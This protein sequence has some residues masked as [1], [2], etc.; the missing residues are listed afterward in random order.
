VF[1]VAEYPVFHILYFGLQK[2]FSDALNEF[3]LN[4]FGKKSHYFCGNVEST[5]GYMGHY[6]NG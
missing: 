4:I 3:I 1:S 6:Y 2:H 5:K